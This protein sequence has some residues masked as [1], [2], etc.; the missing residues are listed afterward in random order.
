[1][2]DC[3]SL[4]M[5]MGYHGHMLFWAVYSCLKVFDRVCG[6]SRLVHVYFQTL[7]TCSTCSF[8]ILTCRNSEPFL[9]CNSCC[10]LWKHGTRRQVHFKKKTGKLTWNPKMKDDVPFQTDDFQI[11][12][13]LQFVLGWHKS[14][15]FTT[16]GAG[17]FVDAC[18]IVWS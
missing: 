6:A 18:G 13:Y 11:P 3:G 9:C 15:P 14:W 7:S 16:H 5:I 10:P 12:C 17:M 4:G 2:W 8:L 1:M